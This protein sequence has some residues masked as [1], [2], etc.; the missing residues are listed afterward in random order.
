MRYRRCAERRI[1]NCLHGPFDVLLDEGLARNRENNRPANPAVLKRLTLNVAR[2][3]P[4]KTF[5][6]RA[7]LKRAGWGDAFLFDGFGHRR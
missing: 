7:K 4:N 3:Q 2:A 6:L 1:E 5:S